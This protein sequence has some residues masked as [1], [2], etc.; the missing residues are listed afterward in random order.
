[1]ALASHTIWGSSAD[2]V[3]PSGTACTKAVDTGPK[4]W[5]NAKLMVRQPQ[6]VLKGHQSI[7]NNVA[8]NTTLPM[9]VTAGVERV[10]KV[11]CQGLSRGGGGG[12]DLRGT[13]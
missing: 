9:L 7:V 2:A 6:Q 12:A 3:P 13:P 10:I 5:S 1:M 8:W 11:C 4:A